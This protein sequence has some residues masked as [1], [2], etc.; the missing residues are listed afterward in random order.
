MEHDPI[1]EYSGPDTAP[2]RR[3]P[4]LL[5]VFLMLLTAVPCLYSCFN[6]MD[7]W[8]FARKWKQYGQNPALLPQIEESAR[9]WTIQAIVVCSISAIGW[10]VYFVRRKTAR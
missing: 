4:G 6:A 5:A 10:S 9:A 2:R 1:I 8:S 3:R 7:T